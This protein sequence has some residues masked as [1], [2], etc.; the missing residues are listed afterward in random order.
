MEIV[1]EFGFVA[2]QE[3]VWNLLMDP[4]VIAKAIPG[5]NELVP[6]EGETSAWRAVAKIGVANVSGSYSGIVRMSEIDPTSQYRLTV[7]GEGQQSIINGTAVI[8]LRYEPDQQQTI[9]SWEADAQISGRLASIG[10]RM[11]KAAAGLMSKQFFQGVAR[12]LPSK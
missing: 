7:S 12:Q 8:K 10:Q 3:T 11:I 5:V 2:D 4:Q 1:G 6:L 9:V